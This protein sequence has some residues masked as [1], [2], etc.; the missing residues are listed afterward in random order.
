MY[1]FVKNYKCNIKTEDLHDNSK[2]KIIM[3]RDITKAKQVH[4]SLMLG[5]FQNALIL[6]TYMFMYVLLIDFGKMKILF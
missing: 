5:Y 4:V 2:N 3:S 6:L 1:T